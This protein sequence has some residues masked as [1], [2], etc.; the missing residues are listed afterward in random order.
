MVLVQRAGL[1]LWVLV[2]PK[3]SCSGVRGNTSAPD[4]Q[5]DDL[6]I[7]TT[8]NG[9]GYRVDDYGSTISTANEPPLKS[10][11]PLSLTGVIEQNT[12]IDLFRIRTTGSLKAT[13]TPAVI[14]PNLDILAEIWDAT[15]SVIFTSNP[16]DALNASFD[17]IVTAGDYF[18]AIRGGGKGDPLGTGYTNYGSLGQYS[19][20]LTVSSDTTPPVATFATSPTLRNTPLDSIG[21]DFSRSVSGVSIGDLTLSRNGVPVNLAAATLT[22]SR[23]NYTLANLGTATAL[24]GDYTLTL[25]A[26]GSGI[27]DIAGIP[28]LVNAR[29]MDA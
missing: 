15:G 24:D 5:Q 1:P 21:I 9:F 11:I 13:L 22:G 6:T 3:N 25:V 28:L 2:T 4:N 18:L 26:A 10:E 14:S 17:L 8:T 20:T 16:L 23:L 29:F 27:V 19:M 12:D 7:I